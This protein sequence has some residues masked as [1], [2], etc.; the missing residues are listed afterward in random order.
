[1]MSIKTLTNRLEMVVMMLP[2]RRDHPYQRVTCSSIDEIWTIRHMTRGNRRIGPSMS[3]DSQVAV[4]VLGWTMMTICLILITV[5]LIIRI[6]EHIPLGRMQT[7]LRVLLSHL[8]CQVGKSIKAMVLMK[9]ITNI[10]RAQSTL[11]SLRQVAP[12]A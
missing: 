7:S 3:R 9:N 5:T 12:V 8:R 1:M 6:L 11:T 10:W 2:V 4:A